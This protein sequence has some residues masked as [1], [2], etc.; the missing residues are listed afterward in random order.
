MTSIYLFELPVCLEWK[1]HSKTV[2]FL[3][4]F[5][6]LWSNSWNEHSS[7]WTS[8]LRAWLSKLPSQCQNSS[9]NTRMYPD[10]T[11][12]TLHCLVICFLMKAPVNRVTP[13]RPTLHINSALFTARLLDVPCQELKAN[14]NR[15]SCEW[16]SLFLFSACHCERSYISAEL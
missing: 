13:L 3:A 11:V 16:C 6:I 9:I 5:L 12:L 14:S 4:L 1:C 10:E 2:F 8:R 7:H 15:M